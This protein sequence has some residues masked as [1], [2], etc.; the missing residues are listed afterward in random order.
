[1]NRRHSKSS[2]RSVMTHHLNRARST[3]VSALPSQ[4]DTDAIVQAALGALAV[5]VCLKLMRIGPIGSFVGSWAPVMA[6]VALFE[7]IKARG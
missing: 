3:A 1:M 6:F 4:R 2:S 5:S 7:R